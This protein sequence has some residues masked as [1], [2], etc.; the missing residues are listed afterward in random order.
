MAASFTFRKTLEQQLAKPIARYA[1]DTGMAQE[2]GWSG[3][4]TDDQI[5]RAVYRMVREAAPKLLGPAPTIIAPGAV[6]QVEESHEKKGAPAKPVKKPVPPTGV[7]RLQHPKKEAA[8]RMGISVR[9]LEYLI[10]RGEVKYKKSGNRVLV[11]EKEVQRF[12]SENHYGPVAG[13]NT[14][15]VT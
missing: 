3:L 7:S 4:G 15:T 14:D 6:V 5:V 9:T 11:H 2:P 8:Y 13:K 10:A 1:W 12:V